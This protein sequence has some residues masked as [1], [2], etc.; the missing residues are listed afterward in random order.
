MSMNL[1]RTAGIVFLLF[2]FL[3][4]S[5]N[6]SS[7]NMVSSGD[8]M[9]YPDTKK[10]TSVYLEHFGTKVA[11]HYRWLEDDMSDETA[12]WVDKQNEVTFSYLEKIPA[13]NLFKERL[14]KIWNYEKVGAPFQRGPYIYYYKNNGLQNQFVLYRKKEGGTEE[15]FIDPN[16]FSKDG[17][18]SLGDI[19]FT[20]DGLLVAYSVSKGGSDWRE[21]IVMDA[22]SKK[23]LEDTLKDIKFS[24]LSW[25]GNEGFYYSSYDKPTGSELSA[26]T[27]QHKLYYHALGT[28][29]KKDVLVFGGKDKRRYVSGMVSEDSR[30]LFVSAANATSGNELYIQRL[31]QEKAEILPLVTNFNNDHDVIDV[32]DGYVYILTNL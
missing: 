23:I 21:V 4:A 12:A 27:D 6:K 10:E 17:T 30:Y 11:D 20:E 18:T 22:I 15:V 13:R 19:S 31:D 5:C 7:K 28:S 8:Q 14:E 2:L 1:H 24:G 16:Q 3:C 9:R 32:R 29:Q 25:K 26:K